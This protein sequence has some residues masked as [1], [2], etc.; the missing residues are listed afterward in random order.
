MA[1]VGGVAWVR[2]E[3]PVAS[4]ALIR[5]GAVTHGINNDHRRISLPVEKLEGESEYTLRV[6]N[7]ARVALPGLYWLFAMDE[8]GVP[9]EGWNIEVFID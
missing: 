8:H 2:T 1:E 3:F 6:P 5:L 7:N 4:F 9:S